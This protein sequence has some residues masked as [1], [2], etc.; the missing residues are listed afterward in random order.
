MAHRRNAA[1]PSAATPQNWGRRTRNRCQARSGPRRSATGAVPLPRVLADELLQLAPGLGVVRL[2]AE[3]LPVVEGRLL[4]LAGP[5]QRPG[6][7][8]AGLRAARIEGQRLPG[9]TLRLL[10]VAGGQV[11]AGQLAGDG[12]IPGID[13][14]ALVQLVG[15]AQ[16]LLLGLEQLAE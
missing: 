4:V 10:D 15:D 7:A 5:R 12:R 14:L 6:Q 16:P 8:D 9:E 11:V 1:T 3:D 2:G 13:E